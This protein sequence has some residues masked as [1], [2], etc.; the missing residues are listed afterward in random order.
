MASEPSLISDNHPARPLMRYARHQV[1]ERIRLTERKTDMKCVFCDIV[2]KSEPADVFYE[3][4][5]VIVFH[6]RYPRAPTHLL[7][8]PREHYTDL[9]DAPP[10]IMPKMFEVVK[11][12]ADKLGT[13]DNG[14]RIVV[15]NGAN[16]GQVIFHLHFHFLT[17]RRPARPAKGSSSG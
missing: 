16:A 14:F 5:D 10:S 11:L 8:C 7:I 6:D 17:H 9:L 2:N 12:V 15:N 4:E 13:G 1:S 3:D